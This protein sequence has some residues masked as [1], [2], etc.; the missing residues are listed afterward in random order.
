MQMFEDMFMVDIA[1]PPDSPLA[2]PRLTAVQ[3]E[4]A[5]SCPLQ[6]QH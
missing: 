4:P 1:L 2:P 3:S 6:L 5:I